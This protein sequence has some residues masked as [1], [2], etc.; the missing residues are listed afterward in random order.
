MKHFDYALYILPFYVFLHIYECKYVYIICVSVCVDIY[1]KYLNWC[2]YTS[3]RFIG[4]K[5]V[6]QR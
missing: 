3:N 1:L 5:N 6:I 4:C 2:S